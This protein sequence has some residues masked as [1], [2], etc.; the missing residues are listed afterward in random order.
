MKILIVEDEVKLA[1]A[2]KAGL[3][4]Q[5]FLADVVYDGEDGYHYASGSEYD[6]ILLDWMLPSM[7]GIEVCRK[8]REDGC[9]TPIIMLTARDG[10]KDRV[11]GL[12]TGADD[13]L[14]KP[15]AFS[16]LTARINSLARRTRNGG[17]PKYKIGDV[18]LDPVAKVATK[19]SKPL[20]LSAKEFQLLEYFLQNQNIVL[21]KEKLIASVWDYDA[22]ILPNTV[23]AF[24]GALRRK[25]DSKS[26]ESYIETIRGMGYKM[27]KPNV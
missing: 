21:S 20:R 10:V 17:A 13:Y 22:D 26:Q 4:H 7:D 12:N 2:I 24:V 1:D 23:E 6:L 8:L 16:E 25:I 27:R 18:A 19:Q 15:F 3:Q 11:E 9:L 14:V 5:G